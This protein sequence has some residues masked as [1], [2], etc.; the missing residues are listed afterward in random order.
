MARIA[1]AVAPG[2][3][4]HVIQRGNRRMQTFFNDDDYAAYLRLMTEWCGKRS[5]EIWAYCLMPNHVHFIMVPNITDGLK[6]AVGEAHRRYTLRINYRNGWRGHL[7]QGRFA[8]YILDNEYLIAAVRYVEMN[9]VKAGL[10]KQPEEW[11]WSS[12]R[13]H[14]LGEVDPVLDES[15]LRQMVSG[16]WKE[17]LLT[18][19]P[20]STIEI[21]KKHE[22][23]GRPLGSKSFI[24]TI[25]KVV[26][27]DLLPKKPGRKS[28]SGK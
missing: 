10:V 24:T 7:W 11:Q 4:H 16:D 6:S 21:I 22:R 19:L 5:V 8:S 28:K 25:E 9:P 17:F 2:F 15:P 18:S 20:E 23:T 13:C 12:A 3:P 14:V 1:R 27:R 26:N